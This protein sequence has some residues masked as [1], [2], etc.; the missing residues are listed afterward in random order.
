MKESAEK[1][2]R[3]CERQYPLICKELASDGFKPPTQ[4]RMA[5][6]RF[7]GV[8]RS[9]RRADHGVVKY[10]GDHPNDIGVDG[11]RRCTACGTMAQACLPR[12]AGQG[13]ADYYRL[14][15]VR[16]RQGGEA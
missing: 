2:Y 1:T 6:E 4:I 9:G 12:L 14:P 11:P 16:T 13:I 3:V 15:E 8:R 7:K 5:V 10:S